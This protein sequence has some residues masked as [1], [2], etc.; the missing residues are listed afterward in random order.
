MELP[1]VGSMLRLLSIAA[2]GV[3]LCGARATA[4]CCGDCNGDGEV[5]I[6][7]IVGA[8]GSA[9]SGCPSTLKPRILLKDVDLTTFSAALDTRVTQGQIS[10]TIEIG[11]N[12][13]ADTLFTISKPHT[14]S[15]VSLIRNGD[16]L[17]WITAN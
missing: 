1:L 10:L 15:S 4:Q 8:V 13:T 2:L 11:A 14:S 17:R 5:S 3:T 12:E 7:E 6:D 16:F 9:L